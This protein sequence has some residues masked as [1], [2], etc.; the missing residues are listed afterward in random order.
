MCSRPHSATSL[1]TLTVM[2]GL[3][4]LKV[5]TYRMISLRMMPYYLCL[6]GHRRQKEKQKTKNQSAKRKGKIEERKNCAKV[7]TKVDKALKARA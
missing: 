1:P 4:S 2:V 6:L 5:V 3:V 7:L